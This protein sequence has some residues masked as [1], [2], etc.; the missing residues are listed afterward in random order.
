MVIKINR[1]IYNLAY[2]PDQLRI[3][4]E[5]TDRSNYYFAFIS[6]IAPLVIAAIALSVAF[7]K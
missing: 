4:T 7:G 5:F 3:K 1:P 2:K 6:A